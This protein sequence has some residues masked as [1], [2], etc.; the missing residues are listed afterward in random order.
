MTVI[1]QVPADAA[2]Y[3]IAHGTERFHPYRTDH[4]DPAS[5]WLVEVPE[6]VAAHLLHVGGF[7][8][9]KKDMPPATTIGMVRLRHSE[10]VGC[11]FAG[12]VYEPDADGV[13]R[14]PA[15]AAAELMAHGFVAVTDDPV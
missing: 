6:E 3:P 13:V 7:A 5:V 10:G 8:V 12:R 11:S 2:D 9:A 1:L 4:T 14:V 15:E